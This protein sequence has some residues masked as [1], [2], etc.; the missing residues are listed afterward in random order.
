MAP[1]PSPSASGPTPA[2]ALAAMGIKSRGPVALRH[3]LA[4][5]AV[6][7]RIQEGQSERDACYLARVSYAAWKGW[8]YLGTRGRKSGWGCDEHGRT[9]PSPDC[10][11]CQ[12]RRTTPVAPF[13]ELA[14]A[15]KW[16]RSQWRA[17]IYKNMVE[18]AKTG[19]QRAGEYVLARSETSR[20]NVARAET[21]RLKQELLR[22]QIRQAGA[23]AELAEK[24]ARGEHVERH[25]IIDPKDPRWAELQREVFGHERQGADDVQAASRH[26]EHGDEDGPDG[27]PPDVDS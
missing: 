21:E 12:R 19:D 26:P 8:I 15:V 13:N 22:A 17:G 5:A 18:R 3:A 20:F 24:K 6:M 27:N 11:L 14:L 9:T 1:P 7:G 25:E 16:Y 4:W 10:P 23:E 2:Q